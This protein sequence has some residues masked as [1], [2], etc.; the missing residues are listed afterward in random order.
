[1]RKF[2]D[3]EASTNDPATLAELKRAW[4]QKARLRGDGTAHTDCRGCC[5][6]LAAG[7]LPENPHPLPLPPA[8]PLSDRVQFEY[9]ARLNPA[10][11]FG[12][13]ELAAA[14][15]RP[16][17]SRW[18]SLAAAAAVAAAACIIALCGHVRRQTIASLALHTALPS[19]F[20]QAMR[21]VVEVSEQPSK[22]EKY[23]DDA[24]MYNLLKRILGV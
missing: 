18:R 19:P 7:F 16:D 17:V 23:K 2:V 5:W 3:I 13:P 12:D 21:I 24:Q 11:I 6:L 14:A 9:A 20:M 4:K 15:L 1:M 22:L 8:P 10:E